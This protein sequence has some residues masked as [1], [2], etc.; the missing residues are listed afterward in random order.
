MGLPWSTTGTASARLLNLQVFLDI[1]NGVVAEC[2]SLVLLYLY[3]ATY[4]SRVVRQVSGERTVV[5]YINQLLQLSA[6]I[7]KYM[8]LL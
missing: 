3:L 2:A 5:D 1:L 6:S 8:L 7:F 4:L